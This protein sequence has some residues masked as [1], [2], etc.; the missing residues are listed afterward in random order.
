MVRIIE[1]NMND[2]ETIEDILFSTEDYVFGYRVAGILV[3]N[4]KVLLQKPTNEDNGYAFPGGHV[5][6]GETNAET[7]TREFKEEINVDIIVTDLKWVAE[8]FCPWGRKRLHQICLYYIVIPSSIDKMPMAN[9]FIGKEEIAGRN[10]NIEFHW[11]PI[12]ETNKITIYPSNAYE[13]LAKLNE[14]VKHF[15]Y[16]EN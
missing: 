2:K 4:N 13:L 16:R 8:I 12:N 15:V 9:K 5:S 10:F 7:L 1:E 14:G 11:I 6:F 3:N